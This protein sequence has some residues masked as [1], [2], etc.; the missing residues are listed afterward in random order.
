LVLPGISV[1]FEPDKDFYTPGEKIGIWVQISD[2]KTDQPISKATIKAWVSFRETLPGAA[3][4][5][6][7]KDTPAVQLKESTKKPG[8]YKGALPAPIV[9]GYYN[10]MAS[11]KVVHKPQI[12]LSELVVVEK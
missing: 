9:E 6:G 12:N 4:V 1:V 2:P 11:V 10:V 7:P 8:Y 5:K 3:P